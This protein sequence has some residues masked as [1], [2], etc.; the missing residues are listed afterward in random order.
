M[1]LSM[2]WLRE[3]VDVSASDREFAEKMTMS[4]SKVEGFKKEGAALKN[5]VV[6]KVLEIKKHPNA[7]KL[8]VC[9]VCV[10][11]K[12]VQIITSATNIAVNDRVSV[13]LDGAILADSTE[14]KSGAIREVLSDGMF[15]SIQ[16]IGVT[17]QDFPQADENGIFILDADCNL[18]E[19][20]CDAIGFNDTVFEFE[21][22]SNRPDCFSV[23]GLARE[24]AATFDKPLNLHTPKITRAIPAPECTVS[25]DVSEPELCP[26]YSA[27]VVKNV[28]IQ[29]SPRWLRERLR[30]MNVRPI[31]NIVD[32]TNY[33]MLEYGQP[34]HA[35][36]LERIAG[37]KI[38]VRRAKS[39]ETITTL[40]DIKRN[41]TAE[42][43]VIA[44]E[45]GPLA[46][47]GV[48]GGE[49]SGVSQDTTTIVFESANF[50]PS[51][52][53]LAAKRHSM[54]TDSSARFEKGLD[55]SNCQPALER[56]CELI[57]ILGAG[58]VTEEFVVCDN[59]TAQKTRIPLDADWLNGFL[60]TNIPK[61]EMVRILSKL[62]LEVDGETV[63]VPSY[64]PDI[65][66]K[67]DIAEEIARFYGYNN[68]ESQPLQG[69]SCGKYSA[70]QK[71]E[72]LVASTMVSLG[73]SE[74]MTYSFISPKDY[75]KILLPAT[76]PRRN[77]VVISNPLGEET[78]VMRTT[79][80]PS[81]MAS[82]A[83]NYNNRN[84]KAHLFELAKEYFPNENGELPEEKNKL[85]VGLYGDATDYFHLK[86]ILEVLLKVLRID[87]YDVC[88]TRED[89]SFHPGRCADFSMNGKSFGIAG[90]IHPTVCQNYGVD[91]RVYVF[92][93]D[94]DMLFEAYKKDVSY[95]PIPKF[96]AVS[97]DIALICD[98]QL[99]VLNL[100]KIISQAAGPLLEEVKLFD[101]YQGEQIEPGKK[102][103]AFRLFLR[104]KDCTLNEEQVS[105]TMQQVI[106]ALNQHG[107]RLRG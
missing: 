74:I 87:E 92:S 24:V 23:I 66:N 8:S 99:A 97:R 2:R 80:L 91:C 85:I 94:L 45:N 50:D 73:L 52:V 27:R 104:A 25:V 40:D 39:G 42:D 19:N 1:N 100:Q 9:Q 107:V 4:G 101:L 57:E 38:C 78:S 84:E 15:C 29:P 77:C 63:V 41:L 69:D 14:I 36:D 106:D 22:T 55:A 44:D 56:A 3:F 83:R 72:S 76:H 35:F 88:A 96:P 81:M 102:S 79:A 49:M 20:I 46:I 65:V 61:A 90:E 54:R 43:L 51:A 17:K 70:R 98:E 30:A 11:E 5:I 33:V 59:H 31:N 68:I 93:I 18:G 26:F 71:F 21:I 82:I 28:K 48:M 86:G 12:T 60:S 64:R 6:G 13:A 47:A 75:D 34:M 62:G 53:R 67:A 89:A 58:E 7:D 32:I 16:E 103:V 95:T 10:G 37:R 105:L